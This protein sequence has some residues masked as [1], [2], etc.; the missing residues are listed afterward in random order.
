MKFDSACRILAFVA[1]ALLPAASSYAAIPVPP[2]GGVFNA[3]DGTELFAP[4]NPMFAVQ[5]LNPFS[6]LFG[7]Y[8]AG[9]PGNGITI[10]NGSDP[11]VFDPTSPTHAGAI[12]SIN[13]SVGEVPGAVTVRNR[14]GTLLHSSP[15]FLAQP[16]AIGFFLT[17]SEQTIYSQSFLNDGLD[18]VGTFSRTANPSDYLIGFYNPSTGSPLSVGG[19]RFLV[20]VPEPETYAMLVAGLGLLLGIFTH[21]RKL[22]DAGA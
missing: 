5:F 7:F 17:I 1:V 2:G 10:F 8:V 6:G 21:R 18:L 15:L 4:S 13:F 20:P 16:G 19:V 14:F 11:A 22:Q 9:D 3:D 12:A